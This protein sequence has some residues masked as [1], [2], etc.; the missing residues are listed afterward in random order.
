MNG[1]FIIKF[2]NSIHRKNTT[3]L[4]N[5]VGAGGLHRQQPGSNCCHEKGWGNDRDR[6][7]PGETAGVNAHGTGNEGRDVTPGPRHKARSDEERRMVDRELTQ[8]FRQATDPVLDRE[9]RSGPAADLKLDERGDV[10][11]D[12]A[13]ET[14][15]PE[16]I[17]RTVRH[18][19]DVGG[20]GSDC[21]EGLN[22]NRDSRGD[23][24][25]AFPDGGR[26]S[27]GINPAR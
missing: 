15:E 26:A 5:E 27:D 19:H 23:Q 2:F 1:S 8:A 6:G 7:A 13:E 9:V 10:P 12:P 22:G 14:P 18:A 4:C 17:D 16:A 21:N 3:P 20:K 25:V 11:A 24:T